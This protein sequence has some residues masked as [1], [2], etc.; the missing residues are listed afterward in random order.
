MV[1]N[2]GA[3]SSTSVTNMWVLRSTC[4]YTRLDKIEDGP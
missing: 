4:G 1:M 3:K 2:V